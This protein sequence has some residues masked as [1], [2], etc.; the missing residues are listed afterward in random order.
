MYAPKTIEFYRRIDHMSDTID[1]II[2]VV[3]FAHTL[4]NT[5]NQKKT[6]LKT[7]VDPKY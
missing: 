4:T 3:C 1:Q 7:G 2:P 5:R 6:I